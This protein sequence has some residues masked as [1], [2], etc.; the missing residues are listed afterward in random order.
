M[1][2]ITGVKF[3]N[4]YE[5]DKIK[6]DFRY[7]TKVFEEIKNVRDFC[8]QDLFANIGG[9]VGMILGVSVLQLSNIILTMIHK[10]CRL[11]KEK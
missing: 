4:F 9:F 3:S 1:R 7:L 11:Y 8:L 2:I 6:I 5:T 10:L